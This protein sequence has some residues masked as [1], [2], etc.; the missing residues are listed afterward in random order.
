MVED[1]ELAAL[2][3]ELNKSIK[4]NA[5][6]KTIN[7]KDGSVI[8]YAEFFVSESKGIIDKIDRRIAAQFGF[9]VPESDFIINFDIKYRMGQDGNCEG[10]E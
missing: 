4:S 7:T 2:G 1:N 5:V 8:E 3:R 10:D 9:S 6:E